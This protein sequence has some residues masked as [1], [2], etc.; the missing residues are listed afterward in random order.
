MR[1]YRVW[2]DADLLLLMELK[3]DG[4]STDKIAEKLNRTPSSVSRKWSRLQ[5]QYSSLATY[6]EV[7]EDNDSKFTDN[8]LLVGILFFTSSI[9][10]I[11]GAL[12]WSLK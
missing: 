12:V 11:I 9:L 6:K 2:S 7:I 4:L 5:K 8:K 10:F 3:A 1:N